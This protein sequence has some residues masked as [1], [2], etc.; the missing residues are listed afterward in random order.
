M[1]VPTIT[2]NNGVG[3]P[4]IGWRVPDAS[5]GRREWR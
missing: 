4:A 2:L 1:T 5:P 3:M